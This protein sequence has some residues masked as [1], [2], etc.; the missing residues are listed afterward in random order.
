MRNEPTF[1]LYFFSCFAKGVCS[2]L[3]GPKPGNVTQARWPV[4]SSGH[5]ILP[6]SAT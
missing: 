1:I 6:A 5:L 2:F 3:G 4:K